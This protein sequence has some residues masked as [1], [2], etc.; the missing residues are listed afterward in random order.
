MPESGRSSVH[1]GTADHSRTEIQMRPV[2]GEALVSDGTA[3]GS[4]AINPKEIINPLPRTPTV[5]RRRT[6]TRN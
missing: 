1:H 6:P 2:L 3:A 5:E 4:I